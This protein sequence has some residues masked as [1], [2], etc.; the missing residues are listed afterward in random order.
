[1]ANS[2]HLKLA[3]SSTSPRPARTLPGAVKFGATRRRIVFVCARWPGRWMAGRPGGE[4]TGPA[5]F[6]TRAQRHG[7]P[8]RHGPESSQGRAEPAAIN[9]PPAR[10][11]ESSCALARTHKLLF[12]LIFILLMDDLCK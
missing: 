11:E 2:F 4:R 3:H 5:T 6:S 1:M 7:R 12:I 8:S 9:C 10:S